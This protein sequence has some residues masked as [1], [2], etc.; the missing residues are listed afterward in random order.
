M[1]CGKLCKTALKNCGENRSEIT[2]A[3]HKFCKNNENV[4]ADKN[5]HHKNREIKGWPKMQIFAYF[6]HS[7][8]DLR[9]FAV[10]R[11]YRVC[12]LVGSQ[13]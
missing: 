11:S 1:Q 2:G 12:E 6:C 5:S 3:K 13:L 9:A 8:A 7:F 10:W 4:K